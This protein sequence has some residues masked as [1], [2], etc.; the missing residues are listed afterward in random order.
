M[1]DNIV[2]LDRP[3]TEAALRRDLVI[4]IQRML[5]LAEAGEIEAIV[6]VPIKAD[7]SFKVM[8]EGTIRKL[9]VVGILAQAQHDLL[10]T[11]GQDP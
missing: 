8:R 4:A 11:D 10:A 6:M 3:T 2:A 7:H 5:N 9:A 1:S